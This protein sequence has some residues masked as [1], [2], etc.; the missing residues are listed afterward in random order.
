[1]KNLKQVFVIAIFG[2]FALISTQ[3]NA[4][5]L[6]TP[7]IETSSPGPT[8]PYPESTTKSSKAKFKTDMATTMQNFVNQLGGIISCAPPFG[9]IAVT[10]LTLNKLESGLGLKNVSNKGSALLSTALYHLQHKTRPA[11]YFSY[12]TNAEMASALQFI[13]QNKTKKNNGVSALFGAINIGYDGVCPDYDCLTYNMIGCII[14][15]N[16]FVYPVSKPK[17]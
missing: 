16:P 4:Q 7:I 15:V 9:G 13:A 2:L 11:Q 12:Y 5:I 10:S 6:T 17:K 8:F 14:E 3:S 1:M